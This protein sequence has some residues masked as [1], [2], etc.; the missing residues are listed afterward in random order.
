MNIPE[1]ISSGIVESYVLGLASPEERSEFEQMCLKH[2]E[3]LRARIAF[4]KLIENQAFDNAIKPYPDI[5]KRIIDQ[6]GTEDASGRNITAPV[7]RIEWLKYAVAASVILLAGSLYWSISL[8]NENRKLKEDINKS[9]ARMDEMKKDMSIVGP[10]PNVK[11]AV[12]KGTDM[13]PESFATIYWDTTSKDVYLVIN[14][15][16]QPPSDKQYQLWALLN[17]QPLDL[18]IVQNDFFIQQNKLLVQMKNVQGAEAFA[19]TLEKQGGSNIPTM[20]SM[21]VMGKL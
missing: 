3:V 15:L 1:Y 20:D 17:G 9:F 18:G 21:Y 10:N 11:M 13:S 2:P 12:L 4:E 19:I 6:I 16:P 8:Y 7:R 14:N 5:K